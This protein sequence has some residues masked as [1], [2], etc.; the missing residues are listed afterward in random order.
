MNAQS[1]FLFLQTLPQ[2]NAWQGVQYCTVL[3]AR[4]AVGAAWEV[5]I[6][7]VQIV[8]CW[9]QIQVSVLKSGG[10]WTWTASLE[11]VWCR[12]AGLINS[13]VHHVT[14]WHGMFSCCLVVLCNSFYLNLQTKHQIIKPETKLLGGAE[15]TQ[16]NAEPL[17]EPRGFL[18]LLQW[19][20]ALV[21]FATCCDF[22]VKFGFRVECK[23]ANISKTFET[24][25]AYPY[26]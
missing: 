5:L 23:D 2:S 22:T 15:M 25:A 18:R 9:C 13:A 6:L 10:D 24:V 1:V 11:Q 16:F 19:L 12:C 20:F 14:P 4:D 17:K 7:S 26:R 3:M 8:D 21:A